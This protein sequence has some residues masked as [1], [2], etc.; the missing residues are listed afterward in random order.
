MGQVG[1]DP[2]DKRLIGV[3]V[4]LASVVNFLV[5]GLLVVVGARE[6]SAFDH[7]HSSWDSLLQE[8]VSGGLVDYQSFLGNE[9]RLD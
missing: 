6:V 2:E 3:L 7:S 1:I 4:M 5:L 8:H 9:S